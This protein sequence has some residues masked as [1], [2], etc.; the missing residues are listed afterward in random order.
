[1][2]FFILRFYLLFFVEIE[3][4]EVVLNEKFVRECMELYL[5]LIKVVEVNGCYFFVRYFNIVDF[6]KYSNNFGCSVI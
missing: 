2:F 4:Y 5:F 6:L 1:M 3:Y